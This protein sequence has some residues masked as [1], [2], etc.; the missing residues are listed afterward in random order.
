MSN[1]LI[2]ALSKFV[3]KG[4]YIIIRKSKF[5]PWL[6]FMWTD[7]VQDYEHYRPET[8]LKHPYL[9]KILFRGK[10]EKRKK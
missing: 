10:V 1:C 8:P 2:F 5:G 3:K 9:S 4:G 6:H 7:N